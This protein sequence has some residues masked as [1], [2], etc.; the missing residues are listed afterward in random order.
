M[1]RAEGVKTSHTSHYSCAL[2]LLPQYSSRTHRTNSN[3][4]PLMGPRW[5]HLPTHVHLS[6]EGQKVGSCGSETPQK[7]SAQTAN[8][9]TSAIINH[10]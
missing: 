2:S 5:V 7:D 6:L 3:I 1:S 4:H 10:V 9:Q 8:L